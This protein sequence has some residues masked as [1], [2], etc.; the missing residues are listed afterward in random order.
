MQEIVIFL[1]FILFL[2][3]NVF[4]IESAGV[5][6]KDILKKACKIFYIL[7]IANII[8][9]FLIVSFNFITVIAFTEDVGYVAYGTTEENGEQVELYTHYYADGDD[10][11][12]QEYEDK[13]YTITTPSIR[14][15]VS[16]TTDIVVKIITSIFCLIIVISITYA[17]M[18]KQG[19]L[20]RT[21]VKY[22]GQK[23]QKHKGFIV[24]VTA[25]IPAI[26]FLFVLTIL[27]SGAAKTFPVLLYAYLNTY[28]YDLI[29]LIAEGSTA[30]GT[31]NIYQ[32]ILFLLLLAIVPIV[33]GVAY[34]LGYNSFSISEKVIYKKN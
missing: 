21:A 26:I 18:W 25:S 3:Y 14:S 2:S 23:E 7:L 20:D 29:S 16:K 11:K 17:E 33:C 10:T 32:I 24:G 5:L 13:G 9:F 12:K 22:K 31:L 30:F 19:D 1:A 6:M 4:Y 28:L 27:K 15:N 34:I 8:S